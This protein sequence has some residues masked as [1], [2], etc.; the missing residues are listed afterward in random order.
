MAKKLEEE[1]RKAEE[2]KHTLDEKKL[3]VCATVTMK[4]ISLVTKDRT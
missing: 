3:K 4:E 2:K 1:Q